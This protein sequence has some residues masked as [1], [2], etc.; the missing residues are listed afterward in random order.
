MSA[1]L[2]LLLAVGPLP[3]EA[4]ARVQNVEAHLNDWDV[5]GAKAELK[6]LRAIAPDSATLAL[7]EG[8]VALEEGRYDDAVKGFEAAE[9]EDEP[10]S[11]LRLAKETRG[12]TQDFQKA[13]SAHFIV[14]FAKGK[15]EVLVP[16]ALE[17]LEAQRAALEQDLGFAPPEKTR[18]ELLGST[19]DLAKVS[20]LS[21]EAIKTTGTIAIC[22]FNKLMVTSPRAAVR[23]YDWLDT[24]AH[25]YTHLVVS[26]KS[27]NTVPIWLHEGF[28][29]YLESRWRGPYG[30][31]MTPSTLAL[32][33]ERVRKN[34]LVPFAKMHPSMALL[35]TAEDAATAFAEVY[36]AADL[37][38]RTQ[39]TAALR[40]VLEGMAKG[41]DDQHAVAKA[42][43]QSFSGFERAWTAHLKAQPFPKELIPRE[44]LQLA[45][46]EAKDKKK[47]PKAKAHEVSFGDFAEVQE[48]AARQW[49]HLGEL[50]RERR[51]F[52]AAVEEYGR[53]HALVQ[54]RYES[55]SN[56]YALALLE[57]G[58]LSEAR[59]VLE[60]SLVMHPNAGPTEVHLGRVTLRQKDYA[61]A[62]T[63]FVKAIAVDPFAEE[64]HLGLY[65]AAKALGDQ[66]LAARA[67]NA[68]ALLLKVSPDAVDKLV[69]QDKASESADEPL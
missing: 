45:G 31:A 10:Q 46:D 5:E 33:G 21:L 66:S 51:R 28:A 42:F 19:R 59:A 39:G 67:R 62:K 15:D 32:L 2:A 57:V 4:K 14:F 60:Q 43:G 69:E 68:A 35:P 6:G 18:V 25:E 20:T 34:T 12:V 65:V 50:M 49:A 13:E 47:D 30:G 36:F 29:K 56:K 58:K 17:A 3:P 16:W 8:R 52:P 26:R 38:Y 1:L 64:T 48:P 23:G 54:N 7:L 40:G 11:W 55:V 22:K 63:A 41:V 24:L 53:A 61:A 9:I 37:L 44:K 27:R